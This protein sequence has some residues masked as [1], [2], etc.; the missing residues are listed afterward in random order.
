MCHDNADMCL[1]HTTTWEDCAR[2]L[3][4]DAHVFCVNDSD[5]RMSNT[6]RHLEYFQTMKTHDSRDWH[7]LSHFS[8]S[9]LAWNLLGCS[10]KI[11]TYV[12]YLY[13]V[14]LYHAHQMLFL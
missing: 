1:D 11:F 14:M 12:D 2:D 8:W 7:P 6:S 13:I 5:T 9:S 10:C 4:A 3:E